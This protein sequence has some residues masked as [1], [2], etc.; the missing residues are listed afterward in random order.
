MRGSNG[1]S[2]RLCKPKSYT[3]LS[4]SVKTCSPKYVDEYLFERDSVHSL[5]AGDEI[6]DLTDPAAAFHFLAGDRR[7]IVNSGETQTEFV[8]ICRS[9]KGLVKRDQA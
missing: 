8:R 6:A 9:A 1:P 4:P 3:Q 2:A 7:S 5:V